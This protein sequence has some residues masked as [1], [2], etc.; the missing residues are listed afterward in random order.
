[1]PDSLALQEGGVREVGDRNYII[2]AQGF[3]FKVSVRHEMMHLSVYAPNG[4]T[5]SCPDIQTLGELI[6]DGLV[7]EGLPKSDEI[8]APVIKPSE[9][10]E[11]S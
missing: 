10:P 2:L 11:K 5:W 6:L 3:R 9:M 4:S 7:V 1:L 8:H